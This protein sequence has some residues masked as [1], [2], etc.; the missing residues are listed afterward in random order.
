MKYMFFII[1]AVNNIRFIAWPKKHL[2]HILGNTYTSKYYSIN[3]VVQI[4]IFTEVFTHTSVTARAKKAR[5]LLLATGWSPCSEPQG[6]ICS[7]DIWS[8]EKSGKAERV[9][10]SLQFLRRSP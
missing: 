3:T 9:R 1:P 10:G 7:A 6:D 4:H 8:Y 2:F 5:F